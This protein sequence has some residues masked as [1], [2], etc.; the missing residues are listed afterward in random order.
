MSGTKKPPKKMLFRYDLP[1]S[2][3]GLIHVN[4]LHI[5]WLV[6]LFLIITGFL[7]VFDYFRD[8]T[9]AEAFKFISYITLLIAIVLCIIGIIQ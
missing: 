9:R 8:Q 7:N 3:L 5:F 4:Q 2:K 6:L 1:Y